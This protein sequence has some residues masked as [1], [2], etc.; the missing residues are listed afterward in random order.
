ML[1]SC[2]SA[3][4]LFSLSNLGFYDHVG[5]PLELKLSHVIGAVVI[6]IHLISAPCSAFE[7]QG[8]Q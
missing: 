8:A 2:N 7:T 5:L 6:T 1:L 4:T 3:S